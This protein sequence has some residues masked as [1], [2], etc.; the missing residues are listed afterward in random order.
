MSSNDYRQLFLLIKDSKININVNSSGQATGFYTQ[1]ELS[2]RII[3]FH[4]KLG[5]FVPERT[6]IQLSTS[7]SI[8]IRAKH[9]DHQGVN[10]GNKFPHIYFLKFLLL[11]DIEKNNSLSVNS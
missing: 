3:F 10:F 2:T 6:N 1:L 4:R 5:T 7:M 8:T 9:F 11:F